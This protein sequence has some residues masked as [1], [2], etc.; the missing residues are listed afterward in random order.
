[1]T[2]NIVNKYDTLYGKEVVWQRDDWSIIYSE[3]SIVC[4]HCYHSGPALIVVHRIAQ[5]CFHTR[6]LFW[7]KCSLHEAMI[8]ALVWAEEQRSD[9]LSLKEVAKEISELSME[10]NDS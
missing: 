2:T 9:L 6:F 7:R 4:I 5:K 10:L 8:K 1:M 3:Q